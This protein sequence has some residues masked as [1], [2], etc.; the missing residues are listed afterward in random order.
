VIS[1][2]FVRIHQLVQHCKKKINSNVPTQN[3]LLTGHMYFFQ[4]AQV[5]FAKW[6]N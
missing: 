4:L 2:E 3:F 6:S 1:Y 5:K